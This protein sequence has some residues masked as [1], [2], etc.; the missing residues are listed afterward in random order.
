MLPARGTSWTQCHSLLSALAAR[1]GRPL[2]G[3]CNTED[4]PRSETLPPGGVK[5]ESSAQNLSALGIAQEALQ[6]G[7]GVRVCLLSFAQPRLS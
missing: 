4:L 3:F 5:G 1:S 2:P 7:A 6:P